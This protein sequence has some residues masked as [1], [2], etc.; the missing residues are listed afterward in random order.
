VVLPGTAVDLQIS[1][2]NGGGGGGDPL[3]K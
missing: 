2:C 1:T 3:P